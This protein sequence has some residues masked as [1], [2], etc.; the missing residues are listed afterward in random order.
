M[1]QSQLHTNHAGNTPTNPK[2]DDSE[3]ESPQN[4]NKS[5]S[6]DNNNDDDD[7]DDVL[8]QDQ[9]QITDYVRRNEWEKKLC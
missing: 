1:F 6:K 9:K 8:D 2:D 5:D 7:D 4:E 3:Y